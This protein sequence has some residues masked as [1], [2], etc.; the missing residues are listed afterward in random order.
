MERTARTSLLLL[1]AAVLFLGLAA[2]PRAGPGA[3]A[4]RAWWVWFDRRDESAETRARVRNELDRKAAERRIRSRGQA[5]T[6]SDL[7]PRAED[8]DAVIAAGGELRVVS[9]WLGAISVEMTVARAARVSRLSHVA[10]VSPVGVRSRA[11][12]IGKP[13]PYISADIDTSAYGLTFPQLDLISVPAAHDL[14]YTGDGVRVAFLDAGFNYVYDHVAL[15]HIPIIDTWD[16]VDGEFE[17][18]DHPHGTRVLSAAAGLDSSVYIGAAP[19]IEVLLARTEDASVEEPVEED[20]FIAGLEWVEM[21]GADLVSASLGYSDWYEPADYDGDTAPITIACDAA[22]ERGLLVISSAGNLGAEGITAPADGDSVLAV[23]ACDVTGD[24]V[25]FS[26]RGPT[27]DGRVKPDVSAVGQQAWLV[28]QNSA[29][30]YEVGSGTSYSCPQVAG[31]AALLLQAGPGL[32]PWDLISVLR[33]TASQAGTPDNA[34]GW[35]YVDA[36]AAVEEVLGGAGESDNSASPRAF[37]LISL[38]PNPSNAGAYA[39]VEMEHAG[40]VTLA[41]FDVTG[42]LVHGAGFRLAP[43]RNR[44]PLPAGAWPSGTYFVRIASR[45]ASH[46]E[47]LTV[48]R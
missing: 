26:S 18:E 6:L 34:L 8:V 35:G 13:A 47:K 7:P 16:F 15:Q 38:Y 9:R 37:H 25:W 5:V 48:I 22:A 31:V 19:D 3:D 20:Y 1:L 42:R 28:A 17:V 44:L 36:L 43:G 27:A 41:V 21:R 40:A 14:G 2:P 12:V 32:L 10:G 23:G 11:P 39:V 4:T 24:S 30:G 46:A 29:V 33:A 45:A